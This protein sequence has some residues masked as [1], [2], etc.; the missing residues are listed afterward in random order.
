[1]RGYNV[2]PSIPTFRL[3]GFT[4]LPLKR[5]TPS[6][7]DEWGVWHEGVKED[8]EIEAN[9]QPLGYRDSLM[10]PESERTKASI[11]I[12]SSEVIKGARE[13]EEATEADEVDWEGYV[14]KVS[15]VH[16]YKMGV[17]NHYKAIAYRLRESAK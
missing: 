6:F 4:L 12:Y 10:L 5:Y 14:W 8:L 17:L 11:K 16:S 13:G 9:V 15:R 3:T 2:K 7:R 1:M